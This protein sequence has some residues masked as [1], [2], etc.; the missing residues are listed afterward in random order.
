[1]FASVPFMVYDLHPCP[2]DRA[3]LLGLP[4]HTWPGKDSRMAYPDDVPTLTDGTVTLRAH[5]EGDLAGLLEQATDPL[6]VEQTTVPVPSTE[7]TSR[8]FAEEVIPRG[9]REN[10]SWAF[11]VESVD[12]SGNPRFCGTVELRN[13]GDRRAEIAYGAHPWARGRGIMLAALNLLLDWGF[14]QQRLETVIWWSNE[15]NWASRRLAWRLGFSF[16]GT[17]RRWLPQRG[18]LHDAWVGALLSTDARLPRNAWL[19][20]P[21][22]AGESVVLRAHEPR[23]APRIVEAGADPRAQHW[24]D[25]PDPYTLDVAMSYIESRRE[26]HARGTTLS[27]VAADPVT[28]ALLANVSLMDIKAGDDAEIGYWTH[29]DARG[30]GVMSEACRLVVR[31]AFVPADDGGLGLK[32]LRILAAEG[33]RA[34]RHVIESNGFVETGRHRESSRLG[35]G[36]WVDCV[37]YDMLAS[38]FAGAAGRD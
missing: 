37:T 22:I 17:V 1:M 34:S 23:D 27:W 31:H 19:D 26:G 36:T 24:L 25:L 38:E 28:D 3:A 12:D 16:D 30:R 18:E 5:R 14:E 33:N 4:N 13:E 15:G 20:V 10:S 32:R 6:M 29:P 21:R 35:D 11:A 8:S 7:D 2:Q 9:W